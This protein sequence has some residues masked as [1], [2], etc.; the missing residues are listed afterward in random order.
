MQF[1]IDAKNG[2]ELSAL[3]FGCMRFPTATGRIDI[4][5]SEHLIIEAVDRGVNYLD[6]AYLYNGNE[7]ALG[8]VR[9][10]SPLSCR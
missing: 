2:N 4:D 7:A 3:G 1:R 9:C 5:A 6:T 10:I 8:G